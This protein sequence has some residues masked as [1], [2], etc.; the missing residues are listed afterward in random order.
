VVLRP[1]DRQ[2]MVVIHILDHSGIFAEIRVEVFACFQYQGMC[3]GKIVD[4]AVQSDAFLDIIRVIFYLTPF[5]SIGDKI[6]HYNGFLPKRQI[7][8]RKKIQSALFS[9]GV[10]PV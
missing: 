7:L 5:D 6:A 1:I 2:K 9:L 8:V 3:V 10:P 4:H